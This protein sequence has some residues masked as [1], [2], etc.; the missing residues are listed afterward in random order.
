MHCLEVSPKVC[1]AMAL[2]LVS[3]KKS[4]ILIPTLVLIS[5]LFS[6][7]MSHF[8]SEKHNDICFLTCLLSPA[9]YSFG[10]QLRWKALKYQRRAGLNVLL[11]LKSE[12]SLSHINAFTC[13]S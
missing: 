11:S 12:C 10:K 2:I 7:T 4:L 9:V 5:Q 1:V 13:K 6:K 8:R 3:L